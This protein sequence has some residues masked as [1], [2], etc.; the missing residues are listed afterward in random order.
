MGGHALPDGWPCPSQEASVAGGRLM[1]V[2]IAGLAGAEAEFDNERVATPPYVAVVAGRIWAEAS[3]LWKA[4]GVDSAMLRQ[5]L[6]GLD[7]AA[8]EAFAAPELTPGGRPSLMRFSIPMTP[9][10][11][12]PRS[13][14]GLDQNNEFRYRGGFKRYG[15]PTINVERYDDNVEGGPAVVASLWDFGHY[16]EEARR[17]IAARAIAENWEPITHHGYPGY[18]VNGAEPR[19]YLSVG[20]LRLRLDSENGGPDSAGLRTALDG[21]DPDRLI[22]FGTLAPTLSVLHD[23]ETEEA[24][25]ANPDALVNALPKSGGGFT[26]VDQSGSYEREEFR[27]VTQTVAMARALYKGAN[28]SDMKIA[29]VDPGYA[30]FTHSMWIETASMVLTEVSR[31]DQTILINHGGW[32]T[33]AAQVVDGR[34]G[35]TLMLRGDVSGNAF[36]VTE[37]MLFDIVGDFDLDRLA[38]LIAGEATESGAVATSCS[39]QECF[40]AAFAAC[41]PA[42]YRTQK[43][44]GARARYEVIGPVEG[45]CRVSLTF[46]S[47]PNPQWVGKALQM[48]L[49]PGAP[50]I[51]SFQ[52]GMN[53]C[54]MH[55]PEAAC[56][57]TLMNLLDGG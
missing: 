24:V 42:S 36:D 28:G 16:A 14:A 53:A 56:E 13:L 4:K 15:G 40:E 57:G 48:N 33:F 54:M 2:N 25:P 46:V 23:P 11:L 44:L 12:L 35:L 45:G 30:G 29:I 8:L 37:D 3:P 49:A 43:M 21:I 55:K 34:F 6:S 19:L 9:F 18:V 51:E 26:L 27:N 5:A 47:N 1:G 32:K 17:L 39:D 52:N 10:F 22:R 41:T 50:F 38:A 7:F 31:G 20:R